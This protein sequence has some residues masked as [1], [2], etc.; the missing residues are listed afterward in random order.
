MVLRYP[1]AGRDFSASYYV[2]QFCWALRCFQRSAV[3]KLTATAA[4]AC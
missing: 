4:T 1:E 3:R 2:R